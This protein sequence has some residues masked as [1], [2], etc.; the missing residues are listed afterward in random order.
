MQNAEIQNIMKIMGLDTS[1]NYE[2]TSA[3]RYGSI[4]IMA[5]QDYDG[6]HIKGLLINM[7]QHWWP[8]L[9]KMPGFLREFITPIVKA[10]K[11]DRVY[12]FFTM[13][14]YESWKHDNN[15]G[16]G[17]DI[18]YYKGLG[19]S[20]SKEAKEYFS[21]LD[22]HMLTFE[23]KDQ[24]D[25]DVIDL[26]F[27]KKRPDDR[28]RWMNEQANS[29][30]ID[31]SKPSVRYTDFV[32]KEL[33]HFARYDVY[34]MIPSIID[35]L[36]PS[37]RKV[38][39]TCLKRK[40]TSDTKV[41]QL[42]G[43]VSELSQ[44]H[45]GEASLQQTIVNIAQDYVGSNNINLLVPSGQFGTRLL[46]GKDAASARY[47]YT[48]LSPMTRLVFHPDDDAIL[49]Y[50]DEEGQKIEPKHYVPIIPIGLVN[51]CEGMGVGWSTTVPNFDP[52]DVITQVKR[53][54]RKEPMEELTPWY[55]NFKGTIVPSE[56]KQ[57]F[58]VMGVIEKT[59]STVVTIT[60]LPVKKWTEDYK[61]FLTTLLSLDDPAHARIQDFK[62]YHTE[63]HVHFVVSMSEDQM[64]RAEGDGF[65]KVFKLRS[66]IAIT[67]MVY[68]SVDG[69]VRRYD[70]VKS[71]LE[72][73]CDVRSTFY[74]KR[75]K[76]LCD[77]L[78]REK[79]FMS[80]KARFI[81]LVIEGKLIVSNRKKAVI[82]VDLK[83]HNF[84]TA[85][86]LG[87][88][89]S[90]GSGQHPDKDESP[91]KKDYDYLLGMPL[92]S[93]TWEHVQDLKLKVEEKVKE[94]D[95]LM[96]TAPE[97]IWMKDLDVLLKALDD[98]DEQYE[99]EQA[100]DKVG[101]KKRRGRAL[102]REGRLKKAKRQR[103]TAGIKSEDEDEHASPAKVAKAESSDGRPDAGI[104]LLARLRQRQKARL[105]M[106]SMLDMKAE[107]ETD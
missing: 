28:K 93:L 69:T 98:R 63:H 50:N 71:I 6:S 20:L 88:K 3:L 105:D 59:S 22:K 53:Y 78:R 66:T 89:E 79:D 1:K 18:K 70:T 10:K 12:T 46:G 42:S 5:D 38:L 85:R 44:Y 91:E 64:R 74:Q 58:D 31:H 43:S 37:Q 95:I 26:A 103:G 23:W 2:D 83:K 21:D 87:E 49:D 34:R 80:E 40:L 99:L 73:F 77:K 14:E 92:W 15:D 24:E 104:S 41:A 68:F 60:E 17:W 100:K 32:H 75:K 52:R 19:T 29:S 13:S 56:T 97:E 36:K 51:G 107:M 45:H 76:F 27:N 11:G 90:E 65:L 101:A 106:V 4:M 55:R 57:G 82:M 62:E 84:K 48:R 30:V 81:L 54:I 9:F 96:H 39:F 86:Q 47:I 33:V 7:I 35:G 67:N 25:S 8:S 16:K 102:T 94:L 72:A 61:N